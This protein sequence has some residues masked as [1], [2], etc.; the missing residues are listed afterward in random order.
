MAKINLVALPMRVQ[1]AHREGRAAGPTWAG[2]NAPLFHSLQPIRATGVVSVM[3]PAAYLEATGGEI[4]DSS[5]VVT[6]L[7]AGDGLGMA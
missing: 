3:T 4:C 1:T 6:T 5:R 2:G 7:H